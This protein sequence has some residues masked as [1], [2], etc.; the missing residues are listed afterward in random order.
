VRAVEEL[1]QGLLAAGVP[2]AVAAPAS[3]AQRPTP[4]P[5]TPCPAWRTPFGPVLGP[6]RPFPLPRPCVV[7][8]HGLAALVPWSPFA[9]DWPRDAV[10]ATLHGVLDRRLAVGV[11]GPKRVWHER[12]DLPLL[13][14]FDG[15]HGTRP[16]EIASAR[17]YVRAGVEPT[18]IPWP[19]G[20]APSP[21]A[22]SRGRPRD[23]YLL[24]VG[25]IHPI[26]GLDRLLAAFAAL[27][28]EH[29]RTRLLVAG[30]G[31]RGET[32]RLAREAARVGV[33][34]RVE[35]LG[36]VDKEP[37]RAL[38]A[39]AA[40]VV[41]PS[42]YENFGM[43]VVEALREG[44]PVVA[45]RETPWEVL[46][47]SGAGRW[48]DFESPSV[49]AAALADALDPARERAFSAAA[50]SL[51]ARELTPEHVVPRFVAFYEEALARAG[52]ASR[53][54]PRIDS[55]ARSPGSPVS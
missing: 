42:R 51:Y 54:G 10:V 6:P 47:T 3:E 25:R 17:P 45:S 39:E 41:L 7:H 15:V 19:L 55:A 1:V 5:V 46:E 22:P 9:R 40:A 35:W 24:Y 38:V 52:A 12:L 53:D 20:D 43:A 11:R 14:R 27:S 48:A 4:V 32:A 18:G 49:A 29:A 37:L 16:S 13:R 28:P 33:R 36:L 30:S 2:S 34:S 8:V 21:G 26:K 44:R 23:P 50:R 31:D